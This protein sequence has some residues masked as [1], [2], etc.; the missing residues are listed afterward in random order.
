MVA[1]GWGWRSG[2]VLLSRSSQDIGLSVW[3]C[4]SSPASPAHLSDGGHHSAWRMDGHH[5]PPWS[6]I[7]CLSAGTPPLLKVSPVESDASGGD[8]LGLFFLAEPLRQNPTPPLCPGRVYTKTLLSLRLWPS[9]CRSCLF[10]LLCLCLWFLGFAVC[11][12]VSPRSP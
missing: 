9:S 4:I 1:G 5:S 6:V 2:R 12:S 11:P 10:D 7:F 8:S 3:V